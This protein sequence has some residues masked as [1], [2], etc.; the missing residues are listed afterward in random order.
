MVKRLVLLVF[1]ICF[2]ILLLTACWDNIELSRLAIVTGIAIDKSQDKQYE[3]SVQII[4]PGSI[5][6]GQSQDGGGGGGD[7]KNY[8]IIS[9]KGRTISEAIWG[10]L[11]MIDRD[12]FLSETQVM[13]IG[14]E[15][16][17]QG[18]SDIAD[19]F[20][21]QRGTQLK[22]DVLVARGVK[23]KEILDTKVE[24][25]GTPAEYISETVKNS[26]LRPKM[27]EMLF[28]DLLKD[29]VRE[30][31]SPVISGITK[32]NGSSITVEGAAVFKKDKFIGWLEPDD[33]RGLIFATKEVQGA[34]IVIPNLH[35]TEESV[36]VEVLK[37][38]NH[39]DV[40][41]E[42]EEPSFSINIEQEAYIAEQQGPTCTNFG[43]ELQKLEEEYKKEIENEVKD[44]LREAQEKFK[45]D[46]FG[47]GEIIYKHNPGYWE[48]VK[49]NWG[50]EF[51]QVQ[52]K[53][54][55][56]VH[57]V[58]TG[59]SNRSQSSQAKE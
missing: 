55:A 48:M 7:K 23:A 25:G 56:T 30:G 28:I 11:S 49:D 34:N 9:S 20:V 47:F 37:S 17:K 6:S 29:I 41:W 45:S 38:R 10:M 4:K 26:R 51:G 50:D 33:T 32:K 5:S 43:Q 16:A 42:N 12:I 22:A 14:E 46:I 57:I 24:T 39:M 40:K 31:K 59:L 58:R 18:I 21:R 1:I 44:T 52:V 3:V 36:S 15:V 19:F 53:V 35:S 2:N 13:I 27:K 54:N 8:Y